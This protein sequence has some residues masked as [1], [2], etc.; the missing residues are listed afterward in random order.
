MKNRDRVSDVLRLAVTGSGVS[1]YEIAKQLGVSESILSRFVAGRHG[2]TLANVDLLAELLG[3]KMVHT[4]SRVK[5]KLD[6]HEQDDIP[7][8]EPQEMATVRKKLAATIA[9]WHK[10][11]AK[12][13]REAHEQDF[14]SRRGAYRLTGRTPGLCLYDN[15]PW[16]DVSWPT[17]EKPESGTRALQFNELMAWCEEQGIK[18][19]ANAAYPP[20]GPGEDQPGYTRALL[21]DVDE[22]RDNDVVR[23]WQAIIGRTMARKTEGPPSAV[24]FRPSPGRGRTTH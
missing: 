15:N 12:V 23:A 13:A 20:P 8:D 11:A 16:P 3:L 14:E 7:A 4:V 19:L 6:A 9:R 17:L 10:A 18:A 2:L 1:R 24:R 5:R 21:L 22:K